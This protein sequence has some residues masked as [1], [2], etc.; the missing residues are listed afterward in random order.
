MCSKWG[1]GLSVAHHCFLARAELLSP[2]VH[3]VEPC[4]RFPPVFPPR[5]RLRYPPVHRDRM[6]LLEHLDIPRVIRVS[7]RR[8]SR[9]DL[10][11]E[12]QSF[13]HTHHVHMKLGWTHADEVPER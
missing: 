6:D 8:H 9:G 10:M 3:A 4:A 12:L 5:D 11:Q 1:A 13:S 7:E 2:F